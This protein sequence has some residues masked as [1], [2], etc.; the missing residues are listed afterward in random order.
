M[1]Y[2]SRCDKYLKEL[3]TMNKIRII[4][5]LLL[6][7]GII[8]VITIQ[9]EEANAK[10]YT[11]TPN[12][13]P[14]DPMFQRYG[15]YNQY[16]KH[17][18]LFRSYMNEF[19]KK[20]GGKLII[21]KGTYN[22]T[23]AIYVPSNVTLEFQNG[24]K[25]VKTTKTGTNIITPS[26]S[27]FQLVSPSKALIDGAYGKYNG[28]KNIKFIGKGTVTFDMKYVPKGI[29]IIM[30][31]NQNVLVDNIQFRNFNYAHFIELDASKNVTIRNS[32][33][34]S[35][36]DPLMSVKEAINIDTPDRETKGWSQRWSKFDAQPN[37]NVLIEHNTFENIPRAVGT[38]KYSE[39]KIHKNITIRN[40]TM[41]NLRNDFIRALNWENA[42]IENNTFTLESTDPRNEVVKGIS[43]SG[44][45]NIRIKNNT[46]DHMAIAMM[47]FTFANSG[48]GS[49]NPVYA[50]LTEQNK[51]DLLS[52]TYLNL[53]TPYIQIRD[54]LQSDGTRKTE[55]IKLDEQTL[56][57]AK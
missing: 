32:T 52:N 8:S 37:T 2:N 7:V 10:T 15:T 29:T 45:K 44:V 47:F 27:M 21:K 50:D 9:P 46:F 16:T 5:F 57:Q 41:K 25:M 4:S 31:H 34:K 28:E 18:Y 17:Y 24:V 43:A 38:H 1:C 51:I 48:G 40:N 42:I 53:N 49:T 6:I 11:I 20:K 30:G 54:N 26:A 35:A 12:S 23:N 39:K 36:N 22:I 56:R 3:I 19:E 33:F 13:K 55:T 14:L